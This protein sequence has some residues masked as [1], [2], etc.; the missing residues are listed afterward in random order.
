MLPTQSRYFIGH[1][2]VMA[3]TVM[4]SGNFIVA[5]GLATSIPPVTLAFLR[6][7]IAAIVLLP[8]VLRP[9]CHDIQVVRRHIGYLSLAAFLLVTVFSTLIYIAAHTSEAINLSLICMCSPLF[10]VV[11]ARLFLK[12]PLTGHRIIGLIAATL[13]VIL[14]ITQGEPSRIMALTFSEGDLWTLVA[15]SVFGAYSVLVRFKPAELSPVV[16]LWSTFILG[17]IFLVPW[18]IWE[19]RDEKVMKFSSTAIGAIVYLGIGPSLIA[20][21]CWNQ[22]IAIVGPVRAAFVYYSL[23]VFSGVAAFLILGEPL[24]AFHLVSGILILT[25]VIIATRESI[26]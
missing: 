3:A 25:G 26:P 2:L 19:L 15:A 5:R 16:F 24:H 10:I 22:A 14:L 8:F 12:D 4:W 9:L 17:L 23:P 21:L 13:G 6:W 1:L 11:L 18:V 7:A 20:Q